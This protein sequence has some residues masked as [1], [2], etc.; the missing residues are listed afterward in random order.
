MYTVDLQIQCK[1]VSAYEVP[2]HNNSDN[3]LTKL[4]GW[5]TATNAKTKT[6]E[7]SEKGAKRVANRRLVYGSIDPAI[8]EAW[9]LFESKDVN[10]TFLPP[11]T[12]S[13]IQP[14]DHP[15]R[16]FK[17][18]Y[19]RLIITANFVAA[20]NLELDCVNPKA[21]FLI[22]NEEAHAVKLTVTLTHQELEVIGLI[23]SHM[24]EITDEELVEI[25]EEKDADEDSTTYKIEKLTL[26][27]LAKILHRL[28]QR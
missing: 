4:A 15:I 24:T 27:G 16:A 6:L 12:S 1:V 10:A 28:R 19:T 22:A 26:E 7:Q 3:D 17:A 13:R 8:P 5:L 25:D 23:E 9:K 14:L 11:N 18:Y 2:Q 21:A 20:M